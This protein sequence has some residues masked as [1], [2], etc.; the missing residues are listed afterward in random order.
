MRE[1]R[2]DLNRPTSARKL[3]PPSHISYHRDADG[4]RSETSAIPSLATAHPRTSMAP[5]PIAAARTR[6][7]RGHLVR[8]ATQ[9]GPSRG[10]R[11]ASPLQPI[12]SRP[13][14]PPDSPGTFSGRLVAARSC[15]SPSADRE[16]GPSSGQREMASGLWALFALGLAGASRACV[17][18]RRAVRLIC[19]GWLPQDGLFGW[20]VRWS[21]DRAWLGPESWLPP[22]RLASIFHDLDGAGG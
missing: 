18:G 13:T 12:R 8:P 16:A 9:T 3:L 2:L 20:S 14:A 22:Y 4:Q 21:R 19:A 15:R 5:P 10:R 6:V 17:S 1:I 7:V 11:A